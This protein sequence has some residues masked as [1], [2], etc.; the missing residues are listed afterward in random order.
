PEHVDDEDDKEEEK[1]DEMKGDDKGCLETRTGKMQIPI[2]TT[3]RSPRINLSSEKKITQ[4]FTNTISLLTSITSKYLHEQR[5]ISNDDA[6]PEGEKRVKRQKTS[7]SSNSV[8]G[9]SSKHSTKDS[10]TYVSKQQHQQ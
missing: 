3:P 5:R 2:P 8:R 7:K 6:P 10:T 1:V 9:S 4:E